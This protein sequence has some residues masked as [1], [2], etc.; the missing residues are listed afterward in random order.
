MRT[1]AITDHTATQSF[2]QIMRGRFTMRCWCSEPSWAQLGTDK[3]DISHIHQRPTNRWTVIYTDV[4]AWLSWATQVQSE[5]T[6][7]LISKWKQA[8]AQTQLARPRIFF[9]YLCL[10]LR[11]SLS[12]MQASYDYAYANVFACVACE[13]QACFSYVRAHVIQMLDNYVDNANSGELRLYLYV[14]FDSVLATRST[15]RKTRAARS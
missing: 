11:R 4:K 15:E 14:S 13:N 2:T 7:A 3:F 1:G 12:W 9:F 5:L 6:I 8:Q 10:W